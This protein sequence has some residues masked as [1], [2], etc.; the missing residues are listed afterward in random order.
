MLI[1]HCFNKFLYIRIN[2]TYYCPINKYGP[3]LSAKYVSYTYGETYVLWF[4]SYEWFAFSGKQK[5]F[6]SLY[7]RLCN[8]ITF[9]SIIKLDSFY[10]HHV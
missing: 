4:I 2:V 6:K 8:W 9:D 1:K 5:L 10:K 7:Y 3:F